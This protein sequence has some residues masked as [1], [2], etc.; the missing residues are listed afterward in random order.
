[1]A[2][3]KSDR[4]VCPQQTMP[5]SHNLL[6]PYP[7]VETLV[8]YSSQNHAMFKIN[9]L[10]PI[11]DLKLLVKDYNVGLEGSLRDGLADRVQANSKDCVDHTH[12]SFRRKG[13]THKLGYGRQLH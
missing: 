11:K 6:R 10:E 7:A 13:Y 9:E 4:L 8:G 12:E 5:L 3:P 1:M 2:I